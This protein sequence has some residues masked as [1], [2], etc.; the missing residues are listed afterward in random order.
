MKIS[1]SIPP[2][3]ID[4]NISPSEVRASVG[5]YGVENISATGLLFLAKQNVRNVLSQ[6]EVYPLSGVGSYRI[7]RFINSCNLGVYL[8]FLDSQEATINAVVIELVYSEFNN[9]ILHQ[10]PVPWRQ[11]LQENPA[12]SS[13]PM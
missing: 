11:N 3:F 1:N 2:S 13:L 4:R 6:K 7:A 8:E 12:L 9:L 10:V 5:L